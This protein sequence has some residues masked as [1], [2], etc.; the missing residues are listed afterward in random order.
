MRK[1]NVYIAVGV[2]VAVAAGLFL[3]GPPPE[4][5]RDNAELVEQSGAV[6]VEVTDPKHE[7]TFDVSVWQPDAPSERLVVISH[8]FDGDRTSHTDLA[9]SLVDQGFVVA[10]PTHPDRGGLEDGSPD[11]DPLVLR[12]RHLELTIDHVSRTNPVPVNDVTVVGHSLGGYSALRLAG[13]DPSADGLD[14]H[15]QQ[16]PDDVVLCSPSAR[17]R[18]N[19][20]ADNTSDVAESTVNRIVLLAPGYGPLFSNA[21]LEA[22]S[23][24]SMTVKAT[25]DR[26]LVGDQVERLQRALPEST[27]VDVDGGHYVFLRTCTEEER[28]VLPDICDKSDGAKRASVQTELATRVVDFIDRP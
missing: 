22:V 18:I 3:I 5:K 27:S 25:N 12:P 21:E 11:L 17:N 7:R 4:Q 10:A 2:V 1:R 23:V 16:H 26:E 28:E 14:N 8:G 19:S 6:L 20:L 9:E 13:A 15:C 24:P